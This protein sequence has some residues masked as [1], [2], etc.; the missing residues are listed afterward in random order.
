MRAVLTP[1]P[2]LAPA[3]ALAIGLSPDVS[4]AWLE[5]KPGHTEELARTIRLPRMSDLRTCGEA[6]LGWELHRLSGLR[7]AADGPAAP[8]RTVVMAKR[9]GPLWVLAPCRVVDVARDA[10]RFSLT[11]ATLPGHPERGVEEFAFVRDSVGVRF[12][13]HA[14]S[15]PASWGSRLL[16]CV[17]RRI[18][19]SATQRYLDA[20]SRIEARR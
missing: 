8:G 16:P 10:D 9:L 17:A 12:D 13:V 1:R 11:Y 5:D 18:Q 14:V 19:G 20:A 3:L 15:T 7:L 2:N 4:A 6:L